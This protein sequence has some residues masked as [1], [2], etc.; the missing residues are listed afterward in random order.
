MANQVTGK[1]ETFNWRAKKQTKPKMKH[2]P[3]KVA[4]A[5]NFS[6][7]KAMAGKSQL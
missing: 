3:G 4:H 7:W 2:R 5:Y 1:K 6:A